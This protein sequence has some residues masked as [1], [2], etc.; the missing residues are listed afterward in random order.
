MPWTPAALRARLATL[1]AELKGAVEAAG[2]VSTRGG[3]ASLNES[4]DELPVVARLVIEVRSD[5]TR[6]IARGALEAEG[7]AVQLE[8]RG[9]TPAQLARTLS[10]ALLT[11]PMLLR[12]AGRRT[13]SSTRTD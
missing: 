2:I 12:P 4:S 1:G 8:A 3:T 9:G 5:G 7:E 6:T 10:R 13:S 11:L